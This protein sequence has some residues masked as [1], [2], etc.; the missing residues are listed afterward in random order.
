MELE[1]VGWELFEMTGN[2]DAYLLYKAQSETEKTVDGKHQ[3]EGL[4]HKEYRLR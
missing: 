2:V 1:N 3:N 4:N